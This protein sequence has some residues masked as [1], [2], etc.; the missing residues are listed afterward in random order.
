LLLLT[1]GLVAGSLLLWRFTPLA[2]LAKPVRLAALLADLQASPW[3]APV[4][5]GLFLIAGL[6]LFPMTVL[7]IVSAVIL[8]PPLAMCTSMLG[9][10][11]SAM[12]SYGI[13]ARFFRNTAVLAAGSQIAQL[14]V[15]LQN[16]GL[17]AIA[18][19][20]FIPV[21]PYTVFN[22]A[23]GAVGVR[24]RDYLGGT[25]LALTPVIALLT[26]FEER[27]RALVVRP[28]TLGIVMLLALAI[29]WV[30]L[31]WGLRRLAARKLSR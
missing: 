21:A 16:R 3:S 14:Q 17:A 22:I 12:V 1:I 8:S 26:L 15:L 9:A 25:A 5:F 4:L 18:V 6:V 28:T 13:G 2:E 23:A 24:V 30:A 20:R 10:L 19:A 27:V 29:G 7:F 31:I 11:C